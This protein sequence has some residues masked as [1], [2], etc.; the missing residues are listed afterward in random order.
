MP[1]KAKVYTIL[2]LNA[3][4]AYSVFLFKDVLYISVLLVIIAVAVS[5]HLILMK[6]I[7]ENE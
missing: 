2:L 3:G 5:T 4:I 1:L 6:T 7:I